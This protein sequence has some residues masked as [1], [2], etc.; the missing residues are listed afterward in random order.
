[1]AMPFF[2]DARH[3]AQSVWFWNHMTIG[4]ILIGGLNSA[5]ISDRTNVIG[6]QLRDAGASATSAA[7]ADPVSD[8]LSFLRSV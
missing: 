2:I 1:M 7:T 4:Q 5:I 8:R 6:K 3:T